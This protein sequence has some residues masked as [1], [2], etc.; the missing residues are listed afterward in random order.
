MDVASPIPPKQVKAQLARDRNF[1]DFASRFWSIYDKQ[2]KLVRFKPNPA[3]QL[4]LLKLDQQRK[5][6]RPGRLRVL[7][8]RQAGSSL[9]WR[10]Y[11]LHQ[12]LLWPGRTAISIA[13]KLDL[14]ADWIRR[15]QE[16]LRQAA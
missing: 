5:D 4:M 1:I 12:V 16:Q 10:L 13:D 7:K 9:L 14:P 15:C 3:Q 6:G 8:Y 11:M 2:G